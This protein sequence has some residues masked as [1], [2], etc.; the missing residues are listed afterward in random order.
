MLIYHFTIQS[1]PAGSTAQIS[2]AQGLTWLSTS[3]EYHFLDGLEPFF[4]PDLPGEYVIRVETLQ[5]YEDVLNGWLGLTSEA[6]V[7][8]VVSG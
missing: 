2:N 8:L 3:Y 4:T 1:A 7:F 5:P 6:L